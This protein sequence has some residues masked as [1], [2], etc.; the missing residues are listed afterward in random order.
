MSQE[1]EKNLKK[2][3]NRQ[4]DAVNQI[5]GPVMVIAGPGTGKTQILAARIGKILQETDT[6]PSQIL[7]LTYTDAGAI[8]MRNRLISFIGPEAYKITI[9]TFHGFCSGIIRENPQEFGQFE[10]EPASDLEKYEILREIIY[11]LPP[12][13]RVRRLRGNILFDIQRLLPLF[14]T[15]KKEDWSAELIVQKADEYIASL[16]E[17]EE[18]IYKVKSGENK[19]GDLKQALYDKEAKKMENLKDAAQIL[20]IYTEKMKQAGLFDY[21]D[22]I[23]WVLNKFKEKP[24]FLLNYQE[25]YLYILVDEYQDTNGSQNEIVQLLSSYFDN[26]NVFVVGDDDQS[27]YRFQGANMENIV[28]FADQYKDSLHQV[29]LL[30]NY[31][32][33]Q[34]ILDTA[35]S[36]I[37]RNEGRLV[38]GDKKKLEAKNSEVASADQRPSIISYPNT[39]HEAAAV[40]E[41]IVELNKSGVPFKEMAVIYTKHD[42]SNDLAAFLQ[43]LKIPINLKREA[44]VFESPIVNSLISILQLMILE[45]E[46]PGAGDGL[47]YPIL[48]ARY[49]EIDPV[50]LQD[51]VLKNRN[52]PF[53]SRK[54]FL[55]FIAAQ[56]PAFDQ[57]DL[58]SVSNETE[59]KAKAPQV[60]RKIMRWMQL[61]SEMTLSVL[62]ERIIYESG[63]MRFILNHPQRNELLQELNTFFNF[64]KQEQQRKSGSDLVDLLD[65][66]ELMTSQGIRLG[67]SK[68][69]R[70]DNGVN[71]M[72]AHGSKGLEFLHVFM[73]GCDQ[74]SWEDNKGVTNKYTLPDNLLL[75]VDPAEAKLEEKRRLFYVAMTRAKLGLYMSYSEEDHNGKGQNASRFVTECNQAMGEDAIPSLPASEEYMI[76]LHEAILTDQGS[77]VIPIFE[78]PRIDKI[79]ETYTLSVTH[80]NQYLKCPIGFFFSYIL[81]IPQAKNPAMEF[82]SAIHRSLEIFFNE[83]KETGKIPELKF[84]MDEAHRQLL[85][86]KESFTKDEFKTKKLYIEEFLPRYYDEYVS[87]WSPVVSIEKRFKDTT[88]EDVPVTGAIDKVSFDGKNATLVDYK[89]G[90]YWRS[91][92]GKKFNRP[93]EKTNK[94]TAHY[95]SEFGGDYWRQA[96]FYKL[97]VQSDPKLDWNVVASEFDFVEPNQNTGKFDKHTFEIT[98]EDEAEV[99][100]Q[101][102]LVFQKIRN[103]EFDTGCGEPDC[104]WCNF[105][106]SSYTNQPH[107]VLEEVE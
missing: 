37:D 69:L 20:P 2:L 84:L 9:S 74:K 64:V 27:I 34:V 16:P 19:K 90:Q 95:V 55:S 79:L 3:N 85:M 12:E 23:L 107:T 7:C 99:R 92:S 102:K 29:V 46:E 62:I 8:A 42:Y 49:F 1:L 66:I 78:D 96:V 70:A 73:I 14:D 59:S 15:M 10:L 105:V 35:R 21:N 18:Y 106:K 17:R 51:Q 50:E 22:M 26:P 57:G 91:T 40:A 83:A 52:A 44:D 103:K 67:V 76:K 45:G 72:T 43:Y 53:K 98:P 100:R 11:D 80:I 82:G 48:S 25:K 6:D 36:L 13:N 61:R 54:P 28:E 24:D 58:F 81:R 4:L 38:K 33:S 5:E 30:D 101:T 32:S 93:G 65:S 56:A 47:V 39:Y 97:L 41:K 75:T 31:R 87:T 104:Q 77:P 60:A 71:M 89:T 63:M 68:S 86:R 88:I 94:D